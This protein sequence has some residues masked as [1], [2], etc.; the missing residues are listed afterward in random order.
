MNF[1]VG[2]FLETE[3]STSSNTFAAVESSYSLMTSTVSLEERLTV[4]D[5]TLSPGQTSRGMDSPVSARV[6]RVDVP[7]TTVP[8][9][10]IFSPGR[11]TILSPTETS[12]GSTVSITPSLR[13][14]ATSGWMSIR[15]EMDLRVFPT[16]RLSNHSPT[17]KNSITA[18][19]S[20]NMTSW[21][22]GSAESRNAPRVAIVIRKFSSNTCPW[23]MLRAAFRSTS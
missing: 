15:S 19:A 23:P 4:P 21:T 14:W 9:S 16:A 3:S 2:A 11:T 12:S 13:T 1:S 10:G 8:S 5:T 7:S 22:P 20:G 6:S 18:T 17:W